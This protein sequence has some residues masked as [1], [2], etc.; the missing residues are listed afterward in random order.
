MII[1]KLMDKNVSFVT[2]IQHIHNDL[3]DLIRDHGNSNKNLKLKVN[4]IKGKK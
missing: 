3:Q 1:V 4:N 2:I